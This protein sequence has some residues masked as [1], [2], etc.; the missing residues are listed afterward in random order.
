MELPYCN[1]ACSIMK[2]DKSKCNLE[3]HCLDD[4]T[5]EQVSKAFSEWFAT[6]PVEKVWSDG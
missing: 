3:G 6:H 2:A 4:F 5:E 1:L